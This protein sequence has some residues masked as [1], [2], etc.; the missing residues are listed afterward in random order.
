MKNNIP[1]IITIALVAAIIGGIIF[2][3]TEK[4]NRPGEYDTFAACIADSGAK[5][6]G[7]YWCPHC[8]SQKDLFGNSAKKL[9]YIECSLPSGNGQTQV[10]ADDGIESYPTWVFADGTKETGEMSLL[11]LA[12]STKCA[13]VKDS[14]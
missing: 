8:Q 9:P 6:Y 12:S 14:I 1:L 13:L 7:A 4:A 5:F 2:Y 3:S 10:C 11:D